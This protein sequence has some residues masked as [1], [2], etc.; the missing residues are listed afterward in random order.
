M[1]RRYSDGFPV[2]ARL[3]FALEAGEHLEFSIVNSGRWWTRGM[4][5][6]VGPAPLFLTVE[7]RSRT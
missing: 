2:V 5:G 7:K 3:P 1:A 6:V 4:A